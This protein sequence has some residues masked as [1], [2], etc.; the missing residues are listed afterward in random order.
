[1]DVFESCAERGGLAQCEVNMWSRTRLVLLSRNLKKSD[2]GAA[3]RCLRHSQTLALEDHIPGSFLFSQEKW[4]HY[5]AM[6]RPAHD[7]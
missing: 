7:L 1:M 6:G 2:S 4:L 5:F 3:G